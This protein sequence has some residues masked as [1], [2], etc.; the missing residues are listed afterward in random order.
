MVNIIF[1]EKDGVLRSIGYSSVN[2]SSNDDE[3]VVVEMAED[4]LSNIFDEAD[5]NDLPETGE[6][7]EAA[8]EDPLRFR[9]FLVLEGGEIAFDE[10]Y[11]RDAHDEDDATP[12]S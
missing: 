2:Y 8:V 11:V 6:P 7:V 3:E 1:K 4:E 10:E 12:G 5:V 9:D